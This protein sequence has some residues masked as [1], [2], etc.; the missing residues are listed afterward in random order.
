M[1][2]D[3]MINLINGM[4][5][6]Y[7]WWLSMKLTCTSSYSRLNQRNQDEHLILW[8]TICSEK[9]IGDDI[10]SKWDKG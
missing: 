3:E 6:Y 4:I 7:N 9:P 10:M 2:I 5:I 1:A 8:V